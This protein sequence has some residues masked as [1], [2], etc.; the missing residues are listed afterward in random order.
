MKKK[1]LLLFMA[2]SL[3]SI[4][5]IGK[6]MPIQLVNNSN[7][8]DNQVY[9]AVIGQHS[10]VGNMWINLAANTQWDAQMKGMSASQNTLHKTNGDWGYG[11]IFYI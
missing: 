10:D 2:I 3:L 11:N 6:S 1:L 5:C 4:T 8:P 9:I 7:F